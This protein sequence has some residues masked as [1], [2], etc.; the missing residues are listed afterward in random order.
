MTLALIGIG[1]NL[2]D[3]AAAVEEALDMLAKLPDSRLT[4]HSSLY[5]TE[6]VEVADQPWFINAA[7]ALETALAPEALL[8]ALLAVEAGF[9]RVRKVDKGPRPL[10]LDLLLYG[11][12]IVS[13]KDLTLPHPRMTGRRFV[14]A[15]L[16]EIAA[17]L[18]HPVENVT[19]KELLN[20]CPDRA[21]VRHLGVAGVVDK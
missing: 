14:L 11:D 21:T 15:P 8:E 4:A 9:G 19:I 18:R 1:A 7:A 3:R 10:D 6:P 20:S 5:E 16:A 2:G 17:T 13:T 12:L